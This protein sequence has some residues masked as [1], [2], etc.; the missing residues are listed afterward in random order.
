MAVAT[1]GYINSSS[2]ADILF[3]SAVQASE[4]YYLLYYSPNSY[5]ADGKFKEIQVKI[6]NK[7]CNI[8]HRAGYFAN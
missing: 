1:G 8:F 7:K 4:N 5:I 2:R 6:K 3:K